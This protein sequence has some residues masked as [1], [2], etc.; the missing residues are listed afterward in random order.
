MDLRR[1]QHHPPRA[2]HRQQWGPRRRGRRSLQGLATHKAI[3]HVFFKHAFCVCVCPC[4]SI[5]VDSPFFST[6]VLVRKQPFS[7]GF[8]RFSRTKDPWKEWARYRWRFVCTLCLWLKR[9]TKRTTEISMV[10]GPRKRDMPVLEVRYGTTYRVFSALDCPAKEVLY[11]PATGIYTEKNVQV[12]NKVP[13]MWIFC[14]MSSRFL[15]K[16]VT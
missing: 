4:F 14:G 6:I 15:L 5:G 16:W 9:E 12:P 10:G 3:D 2:A 7:M 13:N 1:L 8:R 11:K